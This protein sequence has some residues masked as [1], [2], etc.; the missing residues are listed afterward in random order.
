MLLVAL[1]LGSYV[2]FLNSYVA[3]ARYRPFV[4]W[5]WG[6]LYIVMAWFVAI[7]AANGFAGNSALGLLLV[8][9]VLAVVVGLDVK[10]G[11]SAFRCL[12]LGLY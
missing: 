10:T 4:D 1:F 5:M 8:F 3:E 7:T 6:A 12:G 9:A 2:L 11:G